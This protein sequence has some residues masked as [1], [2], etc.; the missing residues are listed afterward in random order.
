MTKF[1]SPPISAHDVS[2]SYCGHGIEPD[3][4][5]WEALIPMASE[6]IEIQEK[7]LALIELEIDERDKRRREFERSILGG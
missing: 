6:D 4:T 3:W 5:L 1:L 7:I 2:V